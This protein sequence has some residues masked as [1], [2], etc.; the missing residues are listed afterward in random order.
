M[1]KKKKPKFQFITSTELGLMFGMSAIKINQE[2][3]KLGYRQVNGQCTASAIQAGLGQ[4][5]TKK[6]PTVTF[7][8]WHRARMPQILESNGLKRSSKEQHV[9]DKIFRAFKQEISVPPEWE[10]SKLEVI[11]EQGA[12]M[13]IKSNLKTMNPEFREKVI[14]L[15]APK[16]RK[17]WSWLADDI[18]NG[19]FK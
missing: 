12:V 4:D 8:M 17:V 15:L 1:S 16:I 10:G 6:K 2:L 5:V 13:E 9:A 3:M 18:E 19:N 14:P 7:G 11:A